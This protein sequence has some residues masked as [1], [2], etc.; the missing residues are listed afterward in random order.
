MDNGKYYSLEGNG[1]RAWELCDGQRTV[2]EI[3]RVME[4]EF[5]APY[6]TIERDIIKMFTEMANENLVVECAPQAGG[7]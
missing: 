4:T 1:G 6:E 3:A 7:A 5:D 2:A